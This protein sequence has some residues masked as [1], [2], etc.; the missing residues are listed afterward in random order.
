MVK[1]ICQDL[2]DTD[3]ANGK[4]EEEAKDALESDVR[5]EL[6][7]RYLEG[8]LNRNLTV[9]QLARHG[10]MTQEEASAKVEGWDWFKANPDS[11][12]TEAD[13]AGY[14]KMLPDLGRSMKDYGLSMDTYQKEKKAIGAFEADKD[15]KGESIPYSKINKAFPYMGRSMKDYGLSMDTYQKEKKAI[16]AFEADKDEKGESIPYSKINKAFPYIRDLPL[17]AEQKTA[18]AVACGWSLKTVEKNKLW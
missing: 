11:D 5:R 15:E 3:M 8:D 17:S 16:G 12:A 13:V 2:I 14:L 4:T 18:L 7:Q 9:R 6:K 1:I 10:G